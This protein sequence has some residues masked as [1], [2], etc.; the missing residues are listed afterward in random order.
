[1]LILIVALLAGL[2][3][4]VRV[5][6][7]R[8]KR[9]AQATAIEGQ[10]SD[11]LMGDPRLAGT[12]LTALA[13]VPLSTHSAPTVEVRGEVESPELA[14]TAVRIV[15]QELLRHHQE[16]RVEERIFVSPSVPTARR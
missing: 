12:V 6:D 5:M 16:G 15:R 7:L 3:L 8:R 10:I 2:V 9:Q 11:A 4:A 1:M 14:E 13:H